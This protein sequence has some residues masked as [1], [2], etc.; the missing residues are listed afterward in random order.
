MF[1]WDNS[2]ETPNAD[3]IYVLFGLNKGEH[4]AL[5]PATV[6]QL[7]PDP[8]PGPD[9]NQPLRGFGRVYFYKPGVSE[10]LGAPESPEIELEGPQRAAVMQQF[11]YGLMLYT[12]IY[13]PTSGKSIFVLYNDGRFDRFDD[14]FGG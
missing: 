1:Y 4:E 9:P 8:T 7:G 5:S 14:T 13:Q 10:R 12:P 11:E 6:S 2:N 3:Y